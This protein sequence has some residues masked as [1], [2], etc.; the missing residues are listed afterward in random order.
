MQAWR[1][2]APADVADATFERGLDVYTDGSAH[3]AAYPDLAR[4]GAAIVQRQPNGDEVAW[5]IRIG[6]EAPRTAP[7][8]EFVAVRLAGLIP[9]TT[10]PRE[11]SSMDTTEAAQVA[12]TCLW[13]DCQAVVNAYADPQFD[14]DFRREYSGQWRD[15]PVGSSPV[16]RHISEVRKVAAHK[17]FRQAHREGWLPQWAGNDRA[18]HY[19]DKACGPP[20]K[21]R[22]AAAAARRHVTA[23][24]LKALSTLAAAFQPHR[25]GIPGTPRAPRA[26]RAPG[27]GR[28]WRPRHKVQW[29]AVL[30]RWHCASCGK[31]GRGTTAAAARRMGAEACAV[32]ERLRLVHPTHF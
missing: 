18:D 4:A 12:N 7:F 11:N 21:A 15:S 32:R 26:E 27:T 22:D 6:D 14:G 10:S 25:E 24:F 8:A 3:N 13:A 17:H 30:G 5:T 20:D 19:A 2:G 1:N 9:W 28:N 31:V 29:E 23:A 16:R